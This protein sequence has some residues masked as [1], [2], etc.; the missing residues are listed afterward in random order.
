[1]AA[2]LPIELLDIVAHNAT[3]KTQAN[4]SAVSRG[5]YSVSIR[6]LYASIPHMNTTRTI[7]CLLTL[8]TSPQVARL[9][10][11]FSLPL[12]SS[13]VVQDDPGLLARGLGNM[14]GL[15]SLSL[16]LGVFAT[17]SV[18][19]P[20]SCRL[21]KFVCVLSSDDAYPIANFLSTQLAIEELYIVCPPDGLTNLQPEA[22]PALRDLAAPL[23]LLPKLL[24]SRVSQI[25]RL[26]VLGTM[27]DVDELLQ[28]GVALET[29]KPPESMELVIGVDITAFLMT[30]DMLAHGLGLLG[31]R[32]PFLNLLRLEIHRGHIRQDGL[33]GVFLHALP[34][35]PKLK[36]L[37]VMSQPPCSSAYIRKFPQAQPAQVAP[38]LLSISNTPANEFSTLSPRYLSPQPEYDEALNWPSLVPDALHDKSCHIKILSAWHQV[39]P[40]LERVVFPVGAYTYVNKKQHK[41]K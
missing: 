12:S 31:L 2:R 7:Q 4:L 40:Q 20:M 24:S 10:R 6:A 28:L 15:T 8:S 1:M 9:V 30:T 13:R 14:T 39:H 25:S 35:H 11:S 38:S 34:K 26:S 17:S 16:Q 23:R 32:A 27:A 3:I 5:A 21:T 18:L 19:S 37:V 33:Q 41:G 22:L 36:T 29:D